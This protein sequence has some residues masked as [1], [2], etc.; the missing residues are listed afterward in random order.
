MKKT[1]AIGAIFLITY[2]GFLIA[3]MPATLLLG[4][5]KL[6]KNVAVIGV[7]GSVWHTKIAQ[8][9]FGKTSIA[10]VD[11]SLSFWSLF[12][13]TPKFNIGFGDPFIA[14]PEGN[15]VLAASAKQIE[16]TELTVLIKANDIAQQLT[17]PLP[18]S[19]QGDVEISI[20]KAAINLQDKNTCLTTDGDVIWSKA[21]VIAL[22][23]NIKLGSLKAKLDCEN[24]A[25]A[26]IISA[27]NNL[28]L[29]FNAYVRQGEP[30]SGNGF[31][32]PGANFPKALNS[33]LSF[34]GE[35]DSQG[36]YRLSF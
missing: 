7:Q 1:F 32:Q 16:V 6:P 35:K 26:V 2:L 23:Q 22:E 9:T 29:T 17:L 5:V 3:T 15:L 30:I 21:G 8:V 20:A 18:V 33:A 24:G 10:K 27:K 4:Q 19:A 11:V 13:L 28:G 12:T 25:F 34:L 31:L 14:G 36:R